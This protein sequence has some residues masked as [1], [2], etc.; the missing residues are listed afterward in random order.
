MTSNSSKRNWTYV[1]VALIGGVAG[2][3][4]GLLMAPAA[5]RDTRR[6]LAEEAG[7]LIDRSQSVVDGVAEYVQ[8]ALTEGRRTLSRV[9]NG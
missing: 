8:E 2:V 9:V 6:R 5:G 3:V 1:G 7:G 4:A